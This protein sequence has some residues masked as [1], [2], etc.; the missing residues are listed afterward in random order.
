MATRRLTFV[1]SAETDAEFQAALTELKRFLDRG[2]VLD[3]VLHEER[4]DAT[5]GTKV[6]IGVIKVKK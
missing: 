3:E 5:G 6:P 2:W 1:L 4:P